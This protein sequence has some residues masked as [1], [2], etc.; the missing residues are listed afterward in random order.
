MKHL[1]PIIGKETASTV[2]GKTIYFL[3]SKIPY[4]DLDG[5]VCGLIGM[6]L[7]ITNIKKKEEQLRN[8]INITSMQTKTYQF[9]TY[10][11]P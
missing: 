1:T 10:C 5:K 8:L 6:S 4:F 7:D 3:T 9:C 2:H 11:F